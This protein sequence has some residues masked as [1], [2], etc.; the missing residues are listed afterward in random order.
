MGLGVLF[1]RPLLEEAH[2]PRGHTHFP[3][4]HPLPLRMHTHSHRH[5]PARHP[6]LSLHTHPDLPYP[7]PHTTPAHYIQAPTSPKR[8]LYP[9]TH[10][11]P[12]RPIPQPLLPPTPTHNYSHTC[13]AHPLPYLNTRPSPTR[14]HP[15]LRPQSLVSH[16]PCA[17][18]HAQRPHL[19]PRRAPGWGGALKDDVSRRG[20]GEADA[21]LQR[22][23]PPRP[24]LGAANP[25][26]DFD[27]PTARLAAPHRAAP[28]PAAMAT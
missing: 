3:K 10:K 9:C 15:H 12:P 27:R 7:Y 13:T 11:H 4:A 26:R 14:A 6:P 17:Q 22:K 18:L 5:T 19:K 28:R 8:T 20:E 16:T 24:H 23:E 21:A 2:T 1:V 25:A